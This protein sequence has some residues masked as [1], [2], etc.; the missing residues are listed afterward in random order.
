M[1]GPRC[2]LYLLCVLPLVSAPAPAGGALGNPITVQID[3]KEFA[4]TPSSIQLSAGRPVRL[5]FINRGQIAHQFDAAYLRT[6][7]LRVVDATVSAEVLGLEVLRV[8]PGASATIEFLP[9]QRG[10]FPFACTIEGH[11]EAGMY[12]ILDMR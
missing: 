6:I 10:R 4:F 1:R 7:P 9:R 12:G 5:V 8:A 3:M 2:L 11:R